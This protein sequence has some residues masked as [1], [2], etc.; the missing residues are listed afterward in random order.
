MTPSQKLA[1]KEEGMYREYNLVICWGA[2][3]WAALDPVLHRQHH[4]RVES[5]DGMNIRGKLQGALQSHLTVWRHTPPQHNALLMKSAPRNYGLWSAYGCDGSRLPAPVMAW[6]NNSMALQP[7]EPFAHSTKSHTVSG[8]AEGWCLYGENNHDD[9]KQKERKKSRLWNTW[10]EHLYLAFLYNI[11]EKENK[12]IC[13]Y[14]NIIAPFC[15][16]FL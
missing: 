4:S 6:E 5:G 12:K 10:C 2:D 13:K 9:W 3:S 8:K 14:S 16:S 15:L 11:A 1:H 7:Q